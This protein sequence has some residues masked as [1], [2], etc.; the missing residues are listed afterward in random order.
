MKFSY[1]KKI[2]RVVLTAK[3]LCLWPLK[4][5]SCHF[6]VQGDIIK[7][8]FFCLGTQPSQ[9]I[10]LLNTRVFRPYQHVKH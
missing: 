9:F 8:T 10:E 3:A 5:L 6:E 7:N 2:L 1:R 4:N